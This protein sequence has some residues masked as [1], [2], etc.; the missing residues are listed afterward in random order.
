[1]ILFMKTKTYLVEIIY[2]TYEDTADKLFASVYYG[3]FYKC[4]YYY[5]Y[6]YQ[7]QRPQKNMWESNMESQNIYDVK[8]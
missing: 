2:I 5:Y 7:E 1:M 6:Y 8:I 3:T 4:E